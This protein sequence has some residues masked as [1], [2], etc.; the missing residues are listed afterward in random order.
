M[1][2]RS[3]H[4]AT[5]TAS[6]PPSACCFSALPSHR[7]PATSSWGA[8]WTGERQAAHREHLPLAILQG[9]VPGE[10]FL[11]PKQ[12]L[13][14]ATISRIYGFHH[15]CKRRYSIKLWKTFVDLLLIA[16]IDDDRIFCCHGDCLPTRSEWCRSGAS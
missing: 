13:E 16:A 12:P 7:R 5:Y 11:A 14:C 9:Q 3:R 1:E 2:N 15:E 6:T 10:L 8:T 4:A